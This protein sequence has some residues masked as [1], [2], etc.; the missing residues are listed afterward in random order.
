LTGDEQVVLSKTV[1]L[2]LKQIRGQF[3]C[4]CGKF[5]PLAGLA[6]TD[7]KVQPSRASKVEQQ[8]KDFSVI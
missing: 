4:D 2:V 7:W 8:N 6:R 5:N 3:D 1:G